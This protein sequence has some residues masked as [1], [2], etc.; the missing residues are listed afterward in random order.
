MARVLLVEDS[1]TQAAEITM[2][3]QAADHQVQ[4]VANGRLGRELLETNL[5]DVVVTDLEMPEMNGL[6]LVESMQCDF[7]HIPAILVT[8]RGSE[9]LATQALRKGAAS[10]VPKDSVPTL[11]NDAIIDVLGVIRSDRSYAKLIARLRKNVFVFELDNDGELISPLIGLMMQVVAG[12]GT[13]GGMQLVRL[14]VAIEHAVV[15]AMYRGNL[16]LSREQTPSDRE[17]IYDDATNDLITERQSSSPYQDRKVTFEA[18]VTE[19]EVRIIVRDQ[20]PGFDTSMVPTPG[21]GER[22][23]REQGRGL[24]MMSSF[25]DE[26]R[27]NEQGNEVTMIKRRV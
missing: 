2:L 3:L 18:I 9:D 22:L 11:L 16:E 23:D 5:F 1:P 27:F 24:M 7:A 17:I 12:L 4:H 10:Y 21:H 8:S 6:E 25:V 15:N 14:G 20:G 26:L 19:Q 13:L